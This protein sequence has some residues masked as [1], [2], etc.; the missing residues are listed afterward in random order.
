M[1]STF[2][3]SFT[4]SP[5]LP[6]ALRQKSSKSSLPISSFLNLPY[7]GKSTGLVITSFCRGYLAT[8]PPNSS[9]SSVT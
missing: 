6:A 8:V 4:L 1:F 3:R 9:A 7:I 5:A 2:S